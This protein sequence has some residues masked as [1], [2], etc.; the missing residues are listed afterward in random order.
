MQLRGPR[1]ER[2]PSVDEQVA[3][4]RLDVANL[5]WREHAFPSADG[6]GFSL[7]AVAEKRRIRIVHRS[8]RDLL[9][10]VIV[11]I[12]FNEFANAR[13]RFARILYQILVMN[14]HVIGAQRLTVTLA[15]AYD[16]SPED[17][18]RQ[19]GTAAVPW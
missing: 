17:G 9:D 8:Q 15:L 12:V 1:F 7:L 2:I 11:Q 6:V 18:G 3:D 10:A 16:P 5:H 14:F 4:A 13:Q 19:E